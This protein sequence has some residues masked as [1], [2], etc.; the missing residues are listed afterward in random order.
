MGL[1]LG[2]C[3]TCAFFHDGVTPTECRYNPPQVIVV[4]GI[5][6]VMGTPPEKIE[7]QWPAVDGND[8]CGRWTDGRRGGVRKTA[9]QI[10][11]EEER[12]D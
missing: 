9:A 12:N 6:R 7:S 1:E 11:N 10:I 3:A 4:T 5:S 8:W 2:T